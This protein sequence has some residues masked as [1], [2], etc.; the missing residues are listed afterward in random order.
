MVSVASE[1]RLVG[2]K[3]SRKDPAT[4]RWVPSDIPEPALLHG[5]GIAG[6]AEDFDSVAIVEWLD[7]RLE[8]VPVHRVQMVIDEAERSRREGLR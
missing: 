8:T 5:F 3:I 1:P 7:G 2:V 4:G 6:T